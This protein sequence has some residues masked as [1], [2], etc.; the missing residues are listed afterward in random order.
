V[1]F[2]VSFSAQRSAAARP[3]YHQ[4]DHR[5]GAEAVG[6]MP[7]KRRPLADRHRPATTEVVVAILLG[8]RL[9]VE[10]GRDSPMLLMRVRHD[11]DRLARH[12]DVGEDP[13]RFRNARSRSC[14]HLGIEMVEVR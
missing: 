14:S 4:V 7:P 12:V 3:E 13:H 10:I 8:Q 1:P 9:A 2:G 6:A 5:I 11:R